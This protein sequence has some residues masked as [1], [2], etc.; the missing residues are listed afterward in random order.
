MQGLLADERLLEIPLRLQL[1]PQLALKL[2]QRAPQ[3]KLAVSESITCRGSDHLLHLP[4]ATLRVRPHLPEVVEE[5][6]EANEQSEQGPL[7]LVAGL[8]HLRAHFLRRARLRLLEHAVAPKSRDLND[9]IAG[10][11]EQHEPCRVL[12]LREEADAGVRQAEVAGGLELVPTV[13]GGLRPLVPQRAV[14]VDAD[15]PG[16]HRQEPWQRQQHD[17]AASERSNSDG[18]LLLSVLAETREEN[19]H[20]VGHSA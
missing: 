5:A 20:P 9:D 12:Q 11:G 14:V 8:A 3:G 1:V 6:D 17:G 10:H 15:P 2:G 18:D 13:V 7:I 16:E 4:G 19:H